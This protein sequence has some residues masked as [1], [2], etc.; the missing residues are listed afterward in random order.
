MCVGML[1]EWKGLTLSKLE[2]RESLLTLQQ[3]FQVH[4]FFG[5]LRLVTQ[6][7][8]VKRNVNAKLE[9]FNANRLM[10]KTILSFRAY[11]TSESCESYRKAC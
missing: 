10:A 11:L 5:K 2:R 3:R 7:G 1:Q 8:E 4:R 9:A 6:I